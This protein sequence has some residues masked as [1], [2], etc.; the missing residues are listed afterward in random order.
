MGTKDQ[1]IDIYINKSREFAKPILNH[2]RELVHQGCPEI[3]ETIKWGFPHFDYK[4]IVCSMASFM[5]S[6]SGK[7]T[8]LKVCRGPSNRL[9][10]LPWDNLEE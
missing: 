8:C 3:Q 10:R 9:G 6:V 1:R 7:E 5:H 2:I 4:G